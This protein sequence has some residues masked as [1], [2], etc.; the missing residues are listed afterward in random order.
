MSAHVLFDSGATR[1]FMSLALS[2]KLRD[3]PG[4]LDSP[5]E[6]KIADERTVSAMRVYQDYVMN[7]L[8]ERCHVDLL[9]I[10]LR[11]MKVNVRMEWL[12]ANGAT[13]ECECHLV[14][15]RTPSGE[16]WLYM[17]RGLRRG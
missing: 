13:I 9:P 17:V 4:T 7:V 16:N 12:G 1:L 8:G 14:R 6:V 15:V 2:K 10:L 5:L 3:V 11:G